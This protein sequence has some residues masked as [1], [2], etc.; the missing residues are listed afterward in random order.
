MTG[1]ASTYPESRSYHIYQIHQN[2]VLKSLIPWFEACITSQQNLSVGSFERLFCTK[3]LS[4]DWITN[5]S[6]LKIGLSTRQV[7]II[8]VRCPSFCIYFFIYLFI[9]CDGIVSW[10]CCK[11][12]AYHLSLL[13]FVWRMKSLPALCCQNVTI[14]RFCCPL[15]HLL[16]TWGIEQLLKDAL[17]V[18]IKSDD[19]KEWHKLHCS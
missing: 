17:N 5:S 12:I 9:C 15:S 13:C 6:W 3:P 1:L 2:P 19:K 16:R 11:I 4:C 7:V 18:S 8:A 14:L 10:Q